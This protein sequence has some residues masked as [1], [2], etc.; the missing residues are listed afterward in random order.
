MKYMSFDDRS[1]MALVN[2]KCYSATLHPTLNRKNL[3]NYDRTKHNRLTGTPYQVILYDAQ[4]FNH[5]KSVLLKT[6]KKILN[7]R[8]IDI[9]HRQL[10]DI[11]LV[12]NIS[13]RI[14]SLHLE[15]I[16]SF[17]DSHLDTITNK[18][19][20][21]EELIL[22]KLKYVDITMKSRKQLLNLRSLTLDYL[23]ISDS[24]FNIII[25][26]VPNLTDL[27]LGDCKLLNWPQ[28]I[29]RFYPT[30]RDVNSLPVFDSPNVFTTCNVVK[31]LNSAKQL[32]NLRLELCGYVFFQLS[33]H[34]ELKSLIL[35]KFMLSL[36]SS[37]P[38]YFEGVNS[39]LSQHISLEK[40]E[41]DAIVCCSLEAVSNLHNLKHLKLM[42]TEKFCDHKTCIFKFF[43]S[44]VKMKKLKTLHFD[45]VKDIM[46]DPSFV[47]LSNNTISNLTSLRLVN[48]FAEY[49]QNV[50]KFGV[51][52]T[53]LEL[54]YLN[55]KEYQ[56]LI[57]NLPR[58]RHLT[59]QNCM[60]LEDNDLMTSPVS[61]LKG[62]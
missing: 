41:I 10:D 55:G 57:K 8:V 22:K 2:T 58:L 39:K 42:V 48:C 11:I 49:N 19:Y 35:N 46:T 12:D 28:A 47:V 14:V 29:R 26:L 51:N 52:L 61:N 6:P 17:I 21:L 45:K 25:Q 44:L 27:N 20:N 37:S 32:T 1:Q 50:L 43:I 54:L 30:Y 38:N 5:F 53:S 9:E 56:L 15:N 24:D 31:F 4:Q 16:D 33:S 62:K 13:N 18:C 23:D 7:V 36:P 3:F 60:D 40:L 34:V 59:I